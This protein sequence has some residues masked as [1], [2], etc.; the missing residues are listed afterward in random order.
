MLRGAWALVRRDAG[1]KLISLV[2]ALLVW[3]GAGNKQPVEY[4]VR[5]PL[6]VRNLPSQF[7]LV[8]DIPETARIRV[9]GK[10]RFFN[11][12]MKDVVAL[13]DASEAEP[14]LFLRPL[15]PQDV[16]LPAGSDAEVREVLAP[17]MVRAEVDHRTRRRVPVEAVLAGVAPEGFTFVGGPRVFPD[18]VDVVGPERFVRH[19]TAA[20]LEDLDLSRVRGEARVDRRV[21]LSGNQLV[22]AVPAEA[23]VSVTVER[24]TEL[25][26][27]AVPVRVNLDDGRETASVTP[28]VVTVRLSGPAS[29]IVGVDPDTLALLIEGSGLPPGTHA[30]R[31]DLVGSNRVLLLPADVS[32]DGR[33]AVAPASGY[34]SA[35]LAI[36]PAIRIVDI[37]PS[38]FSLSVERTG[39]RRRAS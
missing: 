33:E 36:P 28:D 26:F 10:G 15:T 11:F 3:Y 22:Q 4:N 8:G 23:R 20:R 37:V 30:F 13:V 32:A 27:A 2:L 14:G 16:V 35:R 5:I 34:R 12:R 17:R 29:L 21:D 31:T 9:R 39:A 25:R 18:S 7:V 19:I 1:L 24:I 38:H 6:E